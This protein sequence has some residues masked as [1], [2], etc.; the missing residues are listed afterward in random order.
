VIENC[1]K[2][3]APQHPPP[4]APPTLF[5]YFGC[6]NILQ[7]YKHGKFASLLVFS[8]VFF[9]LLFPFAGFSLLLSSEWQS[10][11][12]KTEKK[13][14]NNSNIHS[15]AVECVDK[16]ISLRLTPLGTPRP[17]LSAFQTLRR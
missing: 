3:F 12:E 10:D 13:G 11:R 17:V 14:K 15:I 4:P 7:K 6:I 16:L 2:N 8:F 1:D 9:R 5:S